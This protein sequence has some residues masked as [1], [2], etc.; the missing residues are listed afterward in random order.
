MREHRE[1]VEELG[2]SSHQGS[3]NRNTLQW[4][5]CPRGRGSG[6]K[7]QRPT[8]ASSWWWP[9]GPKARS[10]SIQSIN[11]ML[12]HTEEVHS[13]KYGLQTECI[14]QILFPHQQSF[15]K[16]GLDSSGIRIWGRHGSSGYSMATSSSISGSA[17]PDASSRFPAQG[18]NGFLISG[19]ILPFA[20][21]VTVDSCFPF[22]N[23]H[24]SLSVPSA[25]VPS[26]FPLALSVP[27]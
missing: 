9:P 23:N 25:T 18:H 15:L 6:S 10:F 1:K 27:L 20:S 7:H 12:L 2:V 3:A 5:G 8:S 21:S 26:F 16:Q 4:D 19:N 24:F 22:C 11:H 14:S 13:S 17:V